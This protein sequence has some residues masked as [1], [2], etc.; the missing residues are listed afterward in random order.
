MRHKCLR[1]GWWTE[2][3][4]LSRAVNGMRVTYCCTDETECKRRLCFRNGRRDSRGYKKWKE[5]LR[6]KTKARWSLHVF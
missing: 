5:A 6:D 2:R 4:S 3:E 1:C